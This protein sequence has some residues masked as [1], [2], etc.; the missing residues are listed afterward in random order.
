[1]L[2]GL[3]IL[4]IELNVIGAFSCFLV[5]SSSCSRELRGC[6]SGGVGD[7]DNKLQKYLKITA[8]VNNVF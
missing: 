7:I 4:N 1:M 6:R 2:F 8:I 5:A 3:A